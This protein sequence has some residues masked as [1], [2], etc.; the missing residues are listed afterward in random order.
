MAWT[1]ICCQYDGTY[2]GFLSGVFD[3]Y[4]N[5]EEPVE[6][7]TPEDMCCSLYPLRTVE[8]DEAHAQRVYRSFETFG[9]EG[10]EMAVR[11]FLT[12]LPDKELWL[13][14]FLRLGYRLGPQ[15]SRC[16][17][18]P[19]VD[20]VRKAVWRL[21][22]EAHQYK[23]FTR[24]SQL[25]G[26][27]VGEIEPKNRVLPLLRPH[28]CGRYPQERFVL[29]DRTH[30]EVLFHQ[31]GP[32]GWAILPVEDFQA[33]PAGPEELQYRQLWR[34]FYDTIAIEGRYNPKCRMTHMPKRYWA[35]MTEFQKDWDA[36]LPEVRTLPGQPRE[37]GCSGCTP[38]RG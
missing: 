9:R 33:G 14:R 17:T 34:A 5:R 37:P 1:Q 13:W 18:D 23:G 10:R 24:F 3:C 19:T 8:T 2:P 7:R 31:P 25:N 28:F 29:H 11:C 20:R 16:L 21:E 35:M 38:P 12:C 27:L 15:I 22:H 30:A 32:K 6:F 4:V 26:V 36:A